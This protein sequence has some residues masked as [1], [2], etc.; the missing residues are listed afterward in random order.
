MSSSG[1]S[2]DGNDVSNTT[3]NTKSMA[4]ATDEGDELLVYSQREN[5]KGQE[6]V[7]KV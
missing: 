7:E 2:K 5:F 6:L 1:S 3:T 4:C